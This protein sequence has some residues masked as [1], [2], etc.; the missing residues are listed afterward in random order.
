MGAFYDR[1]SRNLRCPGG[2]AARA[3]AKVRRQM[4]N[5]TR[6]TRPID[7]RLG[8]VSIVLFSTLLIVLDDPGLTSLRWTV[9]VVTAASILGVVTI[10]QR[11]PEAGRS[12]ILVRLSLVL[13]VA[14]SLV[15]AVGAFLVV[16]A[17][18]VADWL[19]IAS[20]SAAFL[21]AVS[22]GSL[23]T[24]RRHPPGAL[25]ALRFL[26]V[27][28]IGG[29]AFLSVFPMQCDLTCYSPL[30]NPVPDT[31]LPSLALGLITAGISGVIL[32]RLSA[33]AHPR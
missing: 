5:A 27:V 30:G 9:G 22:L 13:V 25:P 17:Y 3:L 14:T 18:P 16:G 15:V 20:G 11:E 33:T 29:L 4:A 32:R 2:E 7:T 21:L 26:L 1:D 12:W 31:P 19:W 10:S 23:A 28:T 6:R 24:L 8:I